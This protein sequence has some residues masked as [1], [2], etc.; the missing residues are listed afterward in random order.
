M[1]AVMVTL[2]YVLTLAGQGVVTALGRDAHLRAGLNICRGQ[3]TCVAV[4]E[5]LG[6][7]LLPAEEALAAL[8]DQPA[9]PA[10]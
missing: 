1:I 6:Y 4:A 5:A 8:A 7:P 2:P 3:V 9:V 10:N